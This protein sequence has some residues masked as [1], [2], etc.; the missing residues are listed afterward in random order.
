MEGKE[1]MEGE[2]E[3]ELEELEQWRAESIWLEYLWPVSKW[4]LK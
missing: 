2:E 4:K 1:R 3:I